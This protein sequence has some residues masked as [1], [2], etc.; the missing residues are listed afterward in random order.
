MV[1]KELSVSHV[2]DNAS[3]L[4]QESGDGATIILLL[5]LPLPHSLSSRL[6]ES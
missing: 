3:F 2:R 6:S 5:V 4:Q 1:G